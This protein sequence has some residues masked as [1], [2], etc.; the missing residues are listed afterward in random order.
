MYCAGR[1][2][3]DLVCEVKTAWLVAADQSTK[4]HSLADNDNINATS[5]SA[6]LDI[7]IIR[8]RS[9]QWERFKYHNR[10]NLSLIFVAVLIALN[11]QTPRGV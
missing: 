3:T 5:L 8:P 6:G 7:I 9:C 10:C 11:H 2:S 4:T 1:R